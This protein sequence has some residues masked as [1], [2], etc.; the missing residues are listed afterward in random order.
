MPAVLKDIREMEEYFTNVRIALAPWMN[1]DGCDG[2]IKAAFAI[3]M[4]STIPFREVM[5]DLK[6]HVMYMM[7]RHAMRHAIRER[8]L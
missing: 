5:D 6:S 8:A 4:R 3:S 2:L 7:A 1:E